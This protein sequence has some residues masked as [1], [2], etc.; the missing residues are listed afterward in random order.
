[1]QDVH[2]APSCFAKMEKLVQST[3]CRI[4]VTSLAASLGI[5]QKEDGT[6]HIRTAELTICQIRIPFQTLRYVSLNMDCAESDTTMIA[7]PEKSGRT[8]L[9]RSNRRRFCLIS[10][11]TF[12][13][14]NP[15]VEIFLVQETKVRLY[16]TSFNSRC[17]NSTHLYTVVNDLLWSTRYAKYF[18]RDTYTA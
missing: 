17:D 14:H 8:T 12:S 13:Q 7:I 18:S 4:L 2:L 11:D 1:M 9:I 15:S 6:F 5:C 3:Y 16:A 10:I